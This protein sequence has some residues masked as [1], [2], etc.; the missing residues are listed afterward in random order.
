MTVLEHIKIQ[1]AFFSGFQS[2]MLKTCNLELEH[3][4]HLKIFKFYQESIRSI[5]TISR[6]QRHLYLIVNE[7]FYIEKEFKAK[8]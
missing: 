3:I 7:T 4:E 1:Y 5:I 8:L 2:N 6:I